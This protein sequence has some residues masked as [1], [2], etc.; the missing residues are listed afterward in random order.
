M[1]RVLVTGGAGYIGSCVAE[2]LV[3]RGHVPVIFDTFYWGRQSVE[4]LSD[5][6]VL[7]EGDIR[8]SGQ[9]IYALQNV[10]AV[11]HLA[12]LVGA[13]ACAINHLATYTAN[14]ESTRTLVNCMTDP[15]IGLIRDLVF[16][17]S[18]SIYGNVYGL[19]EQVT[20]DTPVMPLSTYANSKL[21]G[22]RII[23]DKAQEV[24]HFSPTILRLTTIFGWSNR[25][26]FDLVTN[27]FAMKAYEE[28]EIT[29]FGSGEQYRSL[30]HVRDVANA[31]VSVIDMPRYLRDRQIFHVGEENNNITLR[32][33]AMT[34]KEALPD[35]NIVY[36]EKEETDR[37]DYRINCQRI[38][39]TLGW[40]A[41]YSVTDGIDELVEELK[42]GKI[43]PKSRLYRNDMLQ[44]E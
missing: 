2:E 9:L 6:A 12:G 27:Y 16:C 3:A 40:H 5:T 13:P 25:P 26:R 11:I 8:N 7:I 4:H 43:E 21:R 29:I 34:V 23:L 20:E 41:R 30:I 10:D 28:G 19:Y 38:K 24:S 14:V 39:N 44:Y 33:L 42:K 15:D 17:S 31:L 36:A 35:T 18:C 22:E 32:D 1:A 37:R